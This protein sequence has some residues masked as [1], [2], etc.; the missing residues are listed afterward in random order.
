MIKP[1]KIL[2]IK[3]S[4]AGRF[5]SYECKKSEPTE[6]GVRRLKVISGFWLNEDEDPEEAVK[7]VLKE[8]GMIDA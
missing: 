8:M 7:G 5:V 4:D 2:E 1:Y 6:T 3:E